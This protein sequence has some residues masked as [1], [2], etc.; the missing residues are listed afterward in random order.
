M[1]DDPRDI[2]FGSTDMT[3]HWGGSSGK[4]VSK[5]KDRKTACGYFYAGRVKGASS[6]L[7]ALAVGANRRTIGKLLNHKLT[8]YA[9]IKE[10]FKELGSDEFGK[11]YYTIEI[12]QQ[13]LRVKSGLNI[14]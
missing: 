11:K 7:I 3:H 14:R 13:L 9:S 1:P 8:D 5:F 2:M 6:E 12:A 10:E 4:F